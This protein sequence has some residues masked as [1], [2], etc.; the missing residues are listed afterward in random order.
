MPFMM[1]DVATATHYIA[2]NYASHVGIVEKLDKLLGKPR[3]IKHIQKKVF[4]L[5]QSVSAL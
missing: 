1:R 4:N 2:K 3:V 5:K